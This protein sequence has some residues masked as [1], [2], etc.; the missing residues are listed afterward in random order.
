M[1]SEGLSDSKHRVKDSYM[2]QGSPSPLLASRFLLFI[3][4]FSLEI[5][6]KQTNSSFVC[7]KDLFPNFATAVC[8]GV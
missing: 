5:L 7:L 4:F 1:S 8:G 6:V 3:M 2:A